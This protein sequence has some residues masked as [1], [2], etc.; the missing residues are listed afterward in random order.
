MYRMTQNKNKVFQIIKH[1][2]RANR[3]FNSSTLVYRVSQNQAV[4]NWCEIR[5]ID[6]RDGRLL[7]HDLESLISTKYRRTSEREVSRNSV[8]HKNSGSYHCFN[9]FL[10]I[11]IYSGGTSLNS[12]E[13][14]IMFGKLYLARKKIRWCIEP[15]Q[16]LLFFQEGQGGAW[17]QILGVSPH[18]TC[19]MPNTAM[20]SANGS[21]KVKLSLSF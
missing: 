3:V 5:P 16:Q 1:R 19:V 21:I 8:L 15:N 4:I 6:D 11:L 10:F 14:E 2:M 17:L 12:V 18:A 20:I 13:F 7:W 9:L